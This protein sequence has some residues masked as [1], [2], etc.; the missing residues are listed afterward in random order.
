MN[1][2]KVPDNSQNAVNQPDQ[3]RDVNSSFDEKKFVSGVA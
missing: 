3:P 1:T 2:E